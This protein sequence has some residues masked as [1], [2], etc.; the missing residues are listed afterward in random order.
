[1]NQNKWKVAALFF[2]LSF[3]IFSLIGCNSEEELLTS[4][5]DLF[6]LDGTWQSYN[7]DSNYDFTSTIANLRTNG[8]EVKGKVTSDC[9]GLFQASGIPFRITEGVLTETDISLTFLMETTGIIGHFNGNI[10]N[11]PKVS[12]GKEIVGHLYF[13]YSGYLTRLYAVHFVKQSITYLPK[14][15]QMHE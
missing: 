10:K 3:F 14:N 7:F 2:P 8:T 15:S 13:E 6:K 9:F 12:G 4:S 11:N 5:A 1:M